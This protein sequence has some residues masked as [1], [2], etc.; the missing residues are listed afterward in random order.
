MLH[1]QVIDIGFNFLD[2]YGFNG[3]IMTEFSE[4]KHNPSKNTVSDMPVILL[5]DDNAINLALES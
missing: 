5:V 1:S 2:P 4:K 3:L